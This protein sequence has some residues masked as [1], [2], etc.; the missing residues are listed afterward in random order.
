MSKSKVKIKVNDKK[1]QMVFQ[2]YCNDIGYK[3][4]VE[5]QQVTRKILNDFYLIFW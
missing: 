2:K 5:Y 1:K 4:L 3:I